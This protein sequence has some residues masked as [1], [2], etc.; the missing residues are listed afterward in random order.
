LIAE[1]ADG[2]PLEAAVT[3]TLLHLHATATSIEDT[4]A[5]FKYEVE[6]APGGQSVIRGTFS[7]EMGPGLFGRILDALVVRR[8][9]ERSN[10][11]VGANM[12]K[13]FETGHRSNPAAA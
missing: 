3:F 10:A 1:E 8:S 9:I 6:D 5:S 13:F 7:Y 2:N 4:R 11:V 12:K